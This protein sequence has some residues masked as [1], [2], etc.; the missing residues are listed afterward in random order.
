MVRSEESDSSFEFVL[1][2]LSTSNYADIPSSTL[3]YPQ[4]ISR[5]QQLAASLVG[6]PSPPHSFD[7][8][9]VL[10]QKPE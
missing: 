5:H 2:T 9:K 7:T 6:I 8:L 4:N 10:K 1:F 3:K